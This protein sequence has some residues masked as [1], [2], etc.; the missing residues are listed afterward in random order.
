V[1]ISFL[2][3]L[4]RSIT[5]SADV[6]TAAG[7]ER[8]VSL[9]L[10]ELERAF[11]DPRVGDSVSSRVF[12]N[13]LTSVSRTVDSTVRDFKYIMDVIISKYATKLLKLRVDEIEVKLRIVDEVQVV[14]S[15]D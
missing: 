5:L 4:F 11:L 1:T 15:H 9:A 6:D 13:V 8:L 12:V 7:A 10:D 14:S 3:L 2:I